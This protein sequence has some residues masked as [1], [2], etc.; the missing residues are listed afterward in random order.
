[1]QRVLISQVDAVRVHLDQLERST[2]PAAPG[3]DEAIYASVGMR[4]LLDNNAL[5]AVAREYGLS[6]Y[7]DVP[8]FS[9]VPI[10][11]AL[12]FFAGGY[13]FNGHLMPS[14]YLYREP[15]LNSM[16]RRQFE[17]NVRSSPRHPPTIRL[18][19]NKFL[20]TPCLAL[21]GRTVDRST[22]VRYV[23]NRCGGAHHHASRAG[24]TDIDHRLT[25]I[26]SVLK[27]GGNGISAVFLEILGTSW[28]LLQSPEVKELRTALGSESVGPG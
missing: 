13:P 17:D 2:N 3:A 10:D 19:L 18:K 24:F 5:G 15:G 7:V 12:A 28:F 9:G 14:Y 27:L 4:F 21:T 6:I 16:Y 25:D 20:A 23:A 26:G 1:M 11:Q 8:D 22:L